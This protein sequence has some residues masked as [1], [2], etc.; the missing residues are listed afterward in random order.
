MHFPWSMI[1]NNYFYK[2]YQGFFFPIAD[3][4]FARSG[5]ETNR[6]IG[7]SGNSNSEG[8]LNLLSYNYSCQFMYIICIIIYIPLE[9]VWHR[10]FLAKNHDNH[11]Y[12][13]P[14]NIPHNWCLFLLFVLKLI[15]HYDVL[16]DTVSRS[17]QEKTPPESNV[18][19]MKKSLIK[20]LCIAKKTFLGSEVCYCLK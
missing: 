4:S 10:L 1:I 3:L 2:I 11:K 15:K 20:G 12:S 13:F 18:W 19:L 17:N 7:P 16:L 9:Y 5:M 14:F 8:K 6:N